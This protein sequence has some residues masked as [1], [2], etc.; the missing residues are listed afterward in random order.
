MAGCLFAPCDE[1]NTL[2][3]GSANPLKLLCVLFLRA[4]L[5]LTEDAHQTVKC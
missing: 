2:V 3:T 4:S 1:L 5:V